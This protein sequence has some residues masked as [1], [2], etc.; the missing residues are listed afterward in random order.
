M[1]N[2]PSAPADTNSGSAARTP[3]R[4]L[5]IGAVL[6]LIAAGATTAVL[7]GGGDGEE[8]TPVFV[9]STRQVTY[10]VTGPGTAEYLQYVVGAG[11]K[12]KEV[13]APKLPWTITV[14]L[15]VG[16]SGGSI[17]VTAANAG[18][19]PLNCVIKVDGKLAFR[20]TGLEETDVACSSTLAPTTK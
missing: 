16:H 17:Q 14:P 2:A 5:A 11:N 15:D 13:T 12:I 8:Q 19:A 20:A 6:V 4:A 10:E 1:I 18:V 7:M 3:K 9:P